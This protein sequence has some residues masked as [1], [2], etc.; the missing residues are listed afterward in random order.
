[1]ITKYEWSA[2]ILRVVLGV[3]FFVHGLAKFQGGIENTVGWFGSIG[4]PGFLAYG[5]ALLEAAGGI[6]LVVGF[7]TRIVSAL[8]ALL[9]IGAIL[10]VKLAAGFLGN[11]QVAGYE[12]DLAFLAMALS[13]AITGSKLYALDQMIFKGQEHNSKS[14]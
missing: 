8:F 1:M 11:G 9:M 13:I 6:A 5:V 4:L 7:G 12:L 3:T 2:L 10:K 14:A